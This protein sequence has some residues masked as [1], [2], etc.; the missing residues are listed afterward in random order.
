[1]HYKENN[2]LIK[3]TKENAHKWSIVSNRCE[4]RKVQYDE[5]IVFEYIE[6]IKHLLK[7]HHKI[8][9]KKGQKYIIYNFL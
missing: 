2:P 5:Y 3:N 9:D 7:S 4:N 8:K 6:F 1:M